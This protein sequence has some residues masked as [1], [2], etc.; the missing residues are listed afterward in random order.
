MVHY[1]HLAAPAIIEQACALDVVKGSAPR[2]SRCIDY[3][4]RVHSTL[5]VLP[6]LRSVKPQG[7]MR[8]FSPCWEPSECAD[9]SLLLIHLFAGSRLAWTKLLS[10]IM[11]PPSLKK[12]RVI[13]WHWGRTRLRLESISC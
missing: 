5:Q 13:G 2:M 9:R 8:V 7:L 12:G 3:S 11:A 10:G 4:Q 1:H 6:G